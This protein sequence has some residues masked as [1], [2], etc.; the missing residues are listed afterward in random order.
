MGL[1]KK[2][3]STIVGLVVSTI[4]IYLI[5]EKLFSREDP[6][7]KRGAPKNI[8]EKA[9]LILALMSTF[10]SVHYFFAHLHPKIPFV[11]MTKVRVAGF[12]VK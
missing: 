10:A 6:V 11:A 9:S 1:N 12:D 3:A 4:Y 5:S 2:D 8:V 7:R